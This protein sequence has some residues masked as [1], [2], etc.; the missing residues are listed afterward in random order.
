M[1]R[2]LVLLFAIGSLAWQSASDNE[3]ATSRPV[4]TVTEPVRAEQIEFVSFEFQQPELYGELSVDYRPI[5]GEPAIGEEYG[6]AASIGGQ[7]AIATLLFE[8]IGPDGA[9]LQPIPMVSQS[10]G[11]PGD[12]EFIGMMTVPS[13]PFRVRLSGNDVHGQRFTRLSRLITPAADAPSRHVI[14]PGFPPEFVSRIE[15]MFDETRDARYAIVVDNPTGRIALP[16]TRIANVRYAPL[17]SGTGNPLGLKVTYEAEFSQAMRYNP[18]L[19]IYAEDKAD[20]AIGRHPLHPLRSTIQPVPHETYAP[21]KEAEEIPGLLAHRADFLYKAGTRYQF[22][23]EVVPDFVKVL[24]DRITP[25]LWKQPPRYSEHERKAFARQLTQEEPTTYRVW[26]GGR[27]FEGRIDGF[28]GEGTL[29]RSFVAE[30]FAECE[31]PE[32]R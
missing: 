3:P 9:L 8:A 28:Y 5:E 32:Y 14:P 1:L 31:Y 20:S 29:F 24:R 19:R 15:Q 4:R 13:R 6:V 11:V 30:G 27:A 22:A 10:I 26:I 18:E 25:C 7:E 21:L 2:M 23:V 12:Y 17:V 16:R